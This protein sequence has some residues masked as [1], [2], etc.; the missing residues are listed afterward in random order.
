MIKASELRLGNLI[1]E[2]GNITS[3]LTEE[4]LKLK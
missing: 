3:A 1:M 4:E 2:D